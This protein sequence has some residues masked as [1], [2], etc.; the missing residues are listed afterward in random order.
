MKYQLHL[1]TSDSS[2]IQQGGMPAVSNQNGNPFL[3]S[4]LLGAK[5]KNVNTVELKSAEIPIGFYNIRAPYNTLVINGTTYTVPPGNYTI[6]DL[7]AAM[8]AQILGLF[9]ISGSFIQLDFPLYTMTTPFTFTNMGTSGATGP[10]SITYGT[11]TPGYGTSY[12][13][14][15]SGGIQYWTVPFTGTYTFT[16]AGGV[17][18]TTSSTPTAGLGAVIVL[19]Q[20]L[21]SGHVIKILVGQQGEQGNDATQVGGGGGGCSFLYNNTTST[22]LAA[23][24]GGGGAGVVSGGSYVSSMNGKNAN[25]STSGYNG[26]ANPSN[27]WSGGTG[28]TAGGGGGNGNALNGGGG[29]GYSG[30]GVGGALAFLNGGTGVGNGGFGG[31]SGQGLGGG[32]G[33]GGYSGG[34]GGG[35]DKDR[36]GAGGAGGGGSY[37]ISGAYS[38]SATNSAAGYVTI[39]K[40]PIP[41]P[42]PTGG[43]VTTYSSGGTTYKVH[44]FTSSGTFIVPSSIIVDVLIVGG[45][46][47]G[48]VGTQSYYS[49]GGAGGGGQVVYINGYNVNP[50]SYSVTIG[51]GGT[52]TGGVSYNGNPSSVFSSTAVGGNHG[53]D[54]AS[55]KTGGSSGSGYS[56]GSGGNFF[57]GGG[58]GGGAGA[59]GTNGATNTQGGN[60]GIGLAYDISGTSVYYGGGGGG[61]AAQAGVIPRDT[62]GLGGLGGGGNGVPPGDP[63]SDGVPNTGGGGGGGA[64]NVFSN[65]TPLN[66]GYGGSGIVIIRYIVD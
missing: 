3:T 19:K 11:N 37:D 62:Q 5:H 25:I 38:G 21:T 14:T 60:G 26:Y 42:P 65:G 57:G 22:L 13:M 9:S 43:T 64:T 63:R 44:T 34:G 2:N 45:G 50:A 6:T 1:D 58:G 31:G 35:A 32:G 15:L 4:I 7:I 8:N 54:V 40:T 66:S 16:V 55:G 52:N 10:Q 46:G 61:S 47:S 36:I 49:G 17:G 48:G 28:G 23:A 33:G 12:V 27:Q 59:N 56:G 29:G 30:D 18:G 51:D 39:L 41:T 24:G 20:Y 53:S